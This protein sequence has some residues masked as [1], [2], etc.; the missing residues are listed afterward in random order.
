MKIIQFLLNLNQHLERDHGHSW[1]RRANERR[2]KTN[3]LSPIAFCNTF[4]GNPKAKN[5]I[6]HLPANLRIMPVQDFPVLSCPHPV[7]KKHPLHSSRRTYGNK[8]WVVHWKLPCAPATKSSARWGSLKNQALTRVAVFG[9]VSTPRVTNQTNKPGVT[10]L[11]GS[12]N[13]KLIIIWFFSCLTSRDQ[14]YQF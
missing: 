12:V 13:S 11:C 5:R 4:L 14:W 1:I 3:S 8:Y 2:I 7:R 9:S 6:S 10:F